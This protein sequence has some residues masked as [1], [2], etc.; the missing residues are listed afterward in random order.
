LV[1]DAVYREVLPN[2]GRSAKPSYLRTRGVRHLLED[3]R[4][5]I[6]AGGV[7]ADRFLRC[8][9]AT[10]RIL[11][12]IDNNPQSFG[13]ASLHTTGWRGKLF[14]MLPEGQAACAGLASG[15]LNVRE[16]LALAIRGCNE[17]PNL[18]PVLRTAIL[19][20][21]DAFKEKSE[22]LVKSSQLI[23]GYAMGRAVASEY[24][25]RL[26]KNEL[27]AAK[28]VLTFATEMFNK[29]DE[30][31]KEAGAYCLKFIFAA[32]DVDG[33][34]NF[35]HSGKVLLTEDFKQFRHFCA[36]HYD[37]NYRMILAEMLRC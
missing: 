29:D 11:L 18:E 23:S 35:L 14:D 25:R 37:Y 2:L 21:F 9:A 19:L 7:D 33:A 13:D 6:Q 31:L 28:D 36:A 30:D 1:A 22:E 24:K 32:C 20:D 16:L 4:N 5:A 17:I 10:T 15:Q 8:V 12:E 34:G 26:N 27:E 3:A